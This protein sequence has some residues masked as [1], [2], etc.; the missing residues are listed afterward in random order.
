VSLA[1][2]GPEVPPPYRY[3]PLTID[4]GMTIKELRDRLKQFPDA[5]EVAGKFLD[6][7]MFIR[8]AIKVTDA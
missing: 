1:H 3:V 5:G 8:F 2:K 4:E 6:E 7:G